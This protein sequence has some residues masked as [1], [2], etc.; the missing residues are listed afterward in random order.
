MP[1][2]PVRPLGVQLLVTIWQFQLVAAAPITIYLGGHAFFIILNSYDWPDF[3]YFL[4]ILP[5]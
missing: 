3:Y 5:Y 2:Q 4:Y 1:N